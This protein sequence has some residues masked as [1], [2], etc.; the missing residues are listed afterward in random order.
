M[1]INVLPNTNV[2]DT[3]SGQQPNNTY[4]LRIDH[5]IN[6][7]KWIYCNYP[8]RIVSGALGDSDI[9]NK[10]LYQMTISGTAQLFYSHYNLDIGDAIYYGIQIYNP[11]SSAITFTPANYGHYNSAAGT[12]DATA[13]MNTAIEPVVKFYNGTNGLTTQTIAANGSYWID[14]TIAKNSMFSGYL[15]F[16]VSNSAIVT[17]YAYKNKSKIN[18]TAQI[19]PKSGTGGQYSGYGNGY[20]YT[21]KSAIVIKASQ[22]GSGYVFYKSNYSKQYANKIYVSP[23]TT[24]TGDLISINN[25]VTGY[26]GS[27]PIY[28]NVADI[29]PYTGNLGNWGAQYNFILNFVNDTSSTVVFKGYFKTLSRTAST[30]PVMRSGTT[31][32]GAKIGVQSTGGVKDTWKWCEVSVAPNSIASPQQESYQY[33]LG[34]NSN[35]GM[36]HIWTINNLS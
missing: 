18:G 21:S 26:S 23:S 11:N 15:R 12:T 28:T 34:T 13:Y 25:V 10:C 3:L 33:I 27:T 14:Q 4:E 31:T 35:A 7:N 6:T 17:I 36:A 16:S 29:S 32:R 8:E 24:Y 1:A 19:Y 20:Y 2:L 9:S 22:I 5:T 30:Y